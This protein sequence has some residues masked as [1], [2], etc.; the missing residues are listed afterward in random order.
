MKPVSVLYR[1]VG[2][3][4]LEKIEKSGFRK[5][6]PRL[7][8]QPIF[9]V[10]LTSEYAAQ[11]AKDWNTKDEHSGFAGYVTRFRV[12]TDYLEK[13]DIRTVGGRIHREYWIPAEELDEFNANIAGEIEVVETYV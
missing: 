12:R 2:K 1:P 10:V 11:I 3:A 4:E 6:P 9:Y 5:F 13:Y 7:P 8:E